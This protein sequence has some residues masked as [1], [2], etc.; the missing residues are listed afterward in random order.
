MTTVMRS[1][2]LLNI[3]ILE[4]EERRRVMSFLP[5]ERVTLMTAWG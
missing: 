5:I 3:A 1:R 2:R 4:F